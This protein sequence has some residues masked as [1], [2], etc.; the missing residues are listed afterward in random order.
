MMQDGA[1]E[2]VEAIFAA[3]VS[4]EHPTGIIGSRRGPLLAGCGFFRAV[5]SGKKGLVLSP[6]KQIHWILR[7][8]FISIYLLF[9][10]SIPVCVSFCCIP[11]L[12]KYMAPFTTLGCLCDFV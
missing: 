10:I 7:F 3:H 9:K 11:S 1:L 4:H 5:I 12:T 6:A 2:D 8:C